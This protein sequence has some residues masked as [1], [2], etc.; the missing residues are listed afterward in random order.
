MDNEI[1]IK[2]T[3]KTKHIFETRFELE[4][5]SKQAEIFFNK[6]KT[7]KAKFW[8]EIET[9]LDKYDSNLELISNKSN[10]NLLVIKECNDDEK[11]TIQ[12]LNEL[13]R[14]MIGE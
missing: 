12:K 4:L 11:T 14:G 13:F 1:L 6:M 2:K 5:A 3:D 10:E 7:L 9:N 8:A